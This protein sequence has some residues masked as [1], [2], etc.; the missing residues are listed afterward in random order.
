[1]SEITLENNAISWY[2]LRVRPKAEWSIA[3]SLRLAGLE[4]FLPLVRRGRQWS[5]RWKESE[6]PLFP[7]YVFCRMSLEN[8]YRVVRTPGIAGFV[9]FQ[10]VP[11]PIPEEEI[12]AVKR[13]LDSERRL[14]PTALLREGQR[15]KVRSGPLSGLEGLLK[16]IKNERLLVV[17]LNLLQRS[18]AVELDG[19]AVV[20][21]A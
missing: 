10:G 20:P 6:Q 5:D 21:Y 16:R 18:V 3:A 17:N 4:E 15:V 9:G 7:G 8:P 19:D 1:M 13:M 11:A 2:A 12:D 14:R